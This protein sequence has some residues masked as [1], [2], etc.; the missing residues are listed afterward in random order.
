VGLTFD[1][2]R[3]VE[4][5]ACKECGR[6]YVLVKGFVYRDGDAHAVYF[7]ACH[8]HEGRREVWLDVI[9]GSFG[10]GGDN[11]HV[12]FGAHIGAADA[13]SD[14]PAAILVSGAMAYRDAPL[15]GHKLSRDEALHHVWLFDYWHVVDFVLNEDP[16]VATHVRASTVQ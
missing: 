14:E 1:P 9:L 7:A 2:E 6:D 5:H 10:R 3:C 16:T 11:E 13:A 15:W 8:E 12:T 4:L